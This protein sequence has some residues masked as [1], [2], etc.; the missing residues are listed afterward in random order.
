[1]Y[2]HGKKRESMFK[3]IQY[4][5]VLCCVLLT[6][7]ILPIHSSYAVDE[8]TIAQIEKQIDDTVNELNENRSALVDTNEA[9]KTLESQIAENQA[10]IE[11]L[12]LV[13][14]SRVEQARKRLLELQ[15]NDEN[16]SI[17]RVL[18]SSNSIIEF[19]EKLFIVV[20]L[21]EAANS[22]IILAQETRERLS[23]LKVT[24]D[25][26]VSDLKEKQAALLSQMQRVETKRKELDVI[27]ET[28]KEIVAQIIQK[29]EAQLL[30][31]QRALASEPAKQEEVSTQIVKESVS[32]STQKSDEQSSSVI[33]T[34]ETIA[35][36]TQQQTTTQ[37][38]TTTAKTVT[39]AQG[40]VITPMLMTLAEFRVKGVV[41]Y[42]QLKFTYYSELVLPGGGLQIP[43]RHVNANGYVAD[44]DGYI[45]LANDA[46]LGTVIDTPFGAKGKVYDRGTFGNQFDVYIR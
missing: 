7:I 12:N 28:N 11:R 27:L 36:T 8:S 20:Q 39:P 15:I 26:E 33:Q 5:A 18:L 44:K 21:Q 10:E 19:F 22:K 45:V 3:K 4:L 31:Q 6:M 32:S 23:H 46:P 42:N 14:D 1:M 38:V 2:N 37:Q 13:V 41:F 9:I 34:T 29:R 17:L 24:Q 16:T 35:T 40:G 25:K 43:G 30:E